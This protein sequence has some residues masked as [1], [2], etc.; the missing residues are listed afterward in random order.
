MRLVRFGQKDAE[1]PGIVD[2]DGQLREASSMIAD[3]SSATI[4]GAAWQELLR[5]ENVESL[6]KI[7]AVGD[8]QLGPCIGNIGKIVCL[9]LNDKEHAKQL[10]L[11]DDVRPLVF[12]KPQSAITGALGPVVYPKISK[13]MDWETELMVVIGVQCKYVRKEDALKVVAGYCIHND[14]SD[15]F[16]QTDQKGGL[17]ALTSGKSFDT[18]A[19]I[20]PYFVTADEVKT[21]NSLPVKLWVNGDKRQDF[22]TSDYIFTVESTIEYCSQFFTLY[23]GDVISMGSGPGNAEE[24]GRYLQPGDHLQCEIEGLGKQSFTIEA[25]K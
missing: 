3:V 10:G 9:G 1:R 13:K 6:P 16:W 15:R 7:G 2:A 8:A 25:E 14:L 4:G 18:F 22:N 23:P 21:P 20:G 11:G 12:L 17:T 19:P 24:W 5:L